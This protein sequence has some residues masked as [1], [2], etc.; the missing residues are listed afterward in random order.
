MNKEPGFYKKIPPSFFFGVATA[1]HQCEAYDERYADIQDLWEQTRNLTLRNRATDFWNRYEEDILLAKELGCTAFRFSLSWARLE[2][3]PGI[4]NKEAFLH[5][6][7]LISFIKKAGMKPVCTLHHYTWPIHIE[8]RGGLIAADFPLFF[9]QYASKVAEELG[10][11]VIYWVTFN[12][13]N[14]LIYGYFKTGEFKLPPGLPPGT[15]TAR[16]MEKVGLAIPNLFRAHKAARGVLRTGNPLAM[17]GA[18]PFLL[19][20]PRLSRW[21]TDW[22]VCRLHKDSWTRHGNRYTEHSPVWTTDADLVAAMYSR[23][24]EREQSVDFSEVYSIDGLRLLS[25]ASLKK[26]AT[27]QGESIG[28]IRGSTAEGSVKDLFPVCRSQSFMDLRAVA[29]A[30]DKEQVSYILADEGMLQSLTDLHPGTYIYCS[31]RLSQEYYAIG[32]RKGNPDLLELIDLCIRS[33]TKDQPLGQVKNRKV[34]SGLSDPE[35]IAQEASQGPLARGE[36]GTLLRKIQNRGYLIAAVKDDIPGVGFKD[37]AHGFSG[38][39]ID[40]VRKI[41]GLIFGD[42]SRI[43]FIPVVAQK[44]QA[45]ISSIFQCIEPLLKSMSILTAVFNSNWW[46]LGMAGKLPAFL[47]P[48]ECAHE[49]DY[50]GFD[51]Y[52]GVKYFWPASLMALISSSRGQYSKAPVWPGGFYNLLKGHSKLF[53]DQEILIIENGCVDMASGVSRSEYLEAHIGIIRRAISEGIKVR[54]YF[55]WSITTNREWGLKLGPDSDFGLYKIELDTNPHL[56]R[57]ASAASSTLKKIIASCT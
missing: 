36:K 37:P 12:E 34:L 9:E 57:V 54:G 1:D 5:Y 3:E 23:T 4:F 55:C 13:P 41:A 8:K 46:N 21:F 39:E 11:L 35:N 25:L 20:L 53:P 52:W 27:L 16:Q 42:A 50:I 7:A 30:L 44:R 29:D 28:L 49:H 10:D 38:R 24:A 43:R 2:T 31:G 48:E 45:S 32:I 51:Y 17:V 18:N 40:L 33:F 26:A 19:G 47:C 14:Q 15:T 56:C 22:Q 6:R